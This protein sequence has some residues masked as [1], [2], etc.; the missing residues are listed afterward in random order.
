MLKS[1]AIRK[2][3]LGFESYFFGHLLADLICFPL[4]IYKLKLRVA[5]IGKS[6]KRLSPDDI[7]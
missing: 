3:G 5:M 6:S 1:G 7:K 4:Q 2:I